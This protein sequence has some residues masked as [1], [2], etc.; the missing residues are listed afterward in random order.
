[1]RLSQSIDRD[2][3]AEPPSESVVRKNVLIPEHERSADRGLST[4]RRRDWLKWIVPVHTLAGVVLGIV[5]LHPVTMVIYCLEFH[6][7]RA[8]SGVL[9]FVASRMGSAFSLEMWPMTA[10]FALIGA[11]LGAGSGLY[12][13]AITRKLLLVVHLDR[14]MG[15][16]IRSLV[17]AGESA[18]VEFKSSLRWDHVQNRR[19]KDLETVIV[20]T[21]AGFL[22]HDGG[23]L[24][25]GVADNGS[26]VGLDDDYATLRKQDRDGFELLLMRL[27]QNAIGGDVCTLLH[28]VFQEI[29]GR[30]VCRVMIEPSETPVYLRHDG[31]ARYFVRTGNSTCELDTKEA[32]EHILRR[33]SRT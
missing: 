24:L 8:Q 30:D 17:A 21:I 25:I 11:C 13:Q 2:P 9:H 23:D 12:S 32:L 4:K 19:N 16:A 20:K 7:D 14:R 3:L 15:R 10:G 27:V 5:L 22:N 1:M 18:A 31:R 28:V 33:R 26:V 6:P 29:D